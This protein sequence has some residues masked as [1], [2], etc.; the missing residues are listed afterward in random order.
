MRSLRFLRS[1]IPLAVLVAAAFP[2]T[3]QLGPDLTL[4]QG[5]VWTE[6]APLR[7]GLP[8]PDLDKAGVSQ[9]VLKTA[10]HGF[11]G[12][13][14]G[15]R[16][17]YRPLDETRQIK[18]KFVLEPVALIP[19][20]SPGLE[21]VESRQEE[22]QIFSAFR[23]RTTALEQRALGRWYSPKVPDSGGLGKASYHDGLQARALAFELACKE[24]VRAYGR[25]V[26]RNKPARMRGNLALVKLPRY[27]VE[28]GQWV[29]DVHVRLI[30]DSIEPY[31]V[32]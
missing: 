14:Y 8:G 7:D 19:E 24:A 28:S 11:S 16:F 27:R 12:M 3:A 1:L 4:L 29:V 31:R 30:I 6:T 32:F 5:E 26:S 13:I 21:F 25:F 15:Y 23:Y 10:R 17:D 2:L 18:E 20:T 9:A 22:N